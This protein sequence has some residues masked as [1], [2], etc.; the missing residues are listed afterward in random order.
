MQK[1]LWILKK[2]NF[3]F[4]R[5]GSSLM[6]K[7]AFSY[8]KGNKISGDFIEFGTLFGDLS[9]D[10]Y[11]ENKNFGD[12]HGMHFFDSFEGLPVTPEPYVQTLLQPGS[13]SF[14]LEKYTKRLMKFG[15]E[16]DKV[17]IYEGFFT[18]TLR[19]N[20]GPKEV[21]IAWLDCDLYSS[22]YQ[23]LTYLTHRL[24]EGSLLIMDDY[25]LFESSN[26]GARLAISMWL[27]NNPNIKLTA[28]RDFYWGGRAFIFNMQ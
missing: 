20:V 18:E 13:F 8:T 1:A 19:D 6:L 10:A 11:Y 23:V 17:N 16:L 15:V 24:T 3:G 12:R 7:T 4:Q 22:T 5:V 9:I 27:K 21:A 26:K 25:F 14:S 2:K 28:Y